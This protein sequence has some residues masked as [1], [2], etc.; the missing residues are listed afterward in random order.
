MKGGLMA[1]GF[2]VCPCCKQKWMSQNVFLEDPQIKL[3][4]YKADFEKLEYSMLFFNHTIGSCQSTITI[5]VLAF[6]NLYNGHKFPE[7]LTNTTDCPGYCNKIDQLNRCDA[8]CEC[9]YYRE[10]THIINNWKKNIQ[11]KKN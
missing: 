1:N 5:E 11:Y 2:K 6:M 8:L 9:A 4:G 3:I 10:I 7:R